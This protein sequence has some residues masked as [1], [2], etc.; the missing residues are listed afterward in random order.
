MRACVHVLAVLAVSVVFCAH[1]LAQGAQASADLARSRQA[2]LVV[3]DGWDTWKG[4]LRRFERAPGGPWKLVGAP[5]AVVLGKNGLAWGR[6]LVPGGGAGPEKREGD[7]RAPAGVFALGTAF[8]YAPEG[9]R[10]LRIPY[11]RMTQAQECVDDPD[12]PFYNAIVSVSP[13]R[14][15]AWNS[16][17]VMRRKD[18]RYSLGVVVAHNTAP[19]V[20][21]AGSCIF[22][23][24][25]NTPSTYTSGC[26]AMSAADMER[27][28]AWLDAAKHPVLVQLPRAEHPG[29]APRH[30]LP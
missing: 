29:F 17:E 13:R 26:T 18:D 15:K 10:K 6:G 30:G 1:A 16:S 25:W 7:G 20:P 27:V 22:L 5:M 21:G 11:A 4:E 24:V 28:A 19:A 9:R 12:S 3:A 2:L 23:H 14:P 8:G